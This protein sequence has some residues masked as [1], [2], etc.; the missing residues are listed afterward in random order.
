M[1]PKYLIAVLRTM[2]MAGLYAFLKDWQSFLRMHFMYAALESGLLE[3]LTVPS[4]REDLITKLR[5]VR[6]QVLDAILDVGA[7]VRELGYKNGVY[8]IKGKRSRALLG[9]DGDTLSAM[10]QANI[11]YY[12]AAYRNAADRMRGGALGDDL[13]EMGSLVARFSKIAEPVIWELL[14]TL[15]SGKGSMR[16]L[17]VGCGS[18]IF[19]RTIHE[20]NRN[21][22]GIGIDIDEGV[23]KQARENMEHWGL[24]ERFGIIIGDIATPPVDLKGPFNLITLFNVLYCFPSETHF[25][26][27]QK[28]C[29]MLA[30]DG[31]L[32]LAMHFKSNGRDPG[33][34]NLNMV[35]SSL[36]GLTPLPDLQSV[37]GLLEKSGFHETRAER[38][39]PGSTF[40]GIIASSRQ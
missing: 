11:T 17:D 12:S 34:A 18:G 32:A 13:K 38:L 22:T 33:A 20:A 35:N 36:K 31:V 15:V 4:T 26:L 40:Y 39:M 19:M 10:V 30:P 3:A 9:K 7:S 29:S 6:P 8:S 37:I 25:D 28:L 14:T 21:A 1:K 27:L 2:K 23:V 5:A 16:V 24:S